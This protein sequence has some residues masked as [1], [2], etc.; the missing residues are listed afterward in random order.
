MV[1]SCL[2][3]N[4][5]IPGVECKFYECEGPQ[6]DGIKVVQ[7]PPENKWEWNTEV[8]TDFLTYSQ[9]YSLS[10]ETD[11]K[12]NAAAGQR[13]NWC[14]G[15]NMHFDISLDSPYWN[16]LG[17][18]NTAVLNSD[19]NVMVRYKRVRCDIAGTFSTQPSGGGG[20]YKNCPLNSWDTGS[21]ECTN[22][23]GTCI[24]PD[25]PQWPGSEHAKHACCL[26]N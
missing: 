25:D 8:A 16:Q 4:N 19:T 1:N 20:G 3:G 5:I 14:S 9:P 6:C 11:W 17:L 2:V 13:L 26:P 10:P 21:L 24:H 12:A 23:T 22:C 18:G 15:Q 7:N